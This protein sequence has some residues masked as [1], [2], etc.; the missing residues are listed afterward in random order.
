MNTRSSRRGFLGGS[1]AM[2][3][4]PALSSVASAAEATDEFKIGVA[5]YSL[6]KFSRPQAIEMLKKLNIKYISIKEFHLKYADTPEQTVAGAKE[7]RDAGMIIT[8]GGNIDLKKPELL[9]KMFEYAKAAGMPMMVS[10]PSHA[11][12][13]AV[14]KLV[15]E[16]NIKVAIHNHGPEDKEFPSPKSVLDAVKNMDPRVGL[17]MDI[18]HSARAGADIVAEVKS[19]GSRMLDLHIKDLSDT[20]DKASQVAVGDGALPIVKLF[21]ALRQMK[22]TAGVMLE[23]EINADDPYPGMDRSLAYERGVLAGLR[24]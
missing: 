7:F 5:T 9:R 6:R 22:Y 12:L 23:Y 10:A 21:K 4:F 2:A 14:E 24:G 8:S 17:C 16:F 15:K 13:P 3:G 18:G 11:T 20:K 19:A 1:I